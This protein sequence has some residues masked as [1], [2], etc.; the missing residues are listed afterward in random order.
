MPLHVLLSGLQPVTKE[1]LDMMIEGNPNVLDGKQ[2][3]Y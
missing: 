3:N 2:N 1:L